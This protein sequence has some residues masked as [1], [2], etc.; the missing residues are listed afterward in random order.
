MKLSERELKKNVQGAIDPFAI[1]SILWFLRRFAD[2]GKPGYA[3]SYR[4][5]GQWCERC[6]SCTEAFKYPRSREEENVVS[7]DNDR[8]EN[9]PAQDE[10]SRALQPGTPA[11][12][13]TLQSSPDHSVSL[14]DFRGQPVILAFYPADWS[15]VCGDQMTCAGYLSNPPAPSGL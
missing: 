14:R 12:D 11:P 4:N 7:L 3:R 2:A 6:H 1:L 13:F 9:Q 15:P 5:I 10:P 8:R